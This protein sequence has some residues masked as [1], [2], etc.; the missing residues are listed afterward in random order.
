[1]RW[2]TLAALVAALALGVVAALATVH[3]KWNLV[4]DDAFITYR[5]AKNLATGHGIT[6]NLQERPTEGFTSLLHVLLL[7]PLLALRFE[8]LLATRVIS[9]IAMLGTGAL[10]VAFGVRQ[11]RA[12]LL[13]SLLLVAPL[14][15]SS[16]AYELAWS[17]WRRGSSPSCSSPRG[18]WVNPCCASRTS[19]DAPRSSG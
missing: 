10:I 9:V 19:A 11:V 8:P 12:S 4:F 3:T 7:G 5:Y 15:A 16:A 14:F 13:V 1:M 18:S 17:A 2:L 6:W